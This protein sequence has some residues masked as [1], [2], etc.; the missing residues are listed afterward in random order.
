[1]AEAR[2]QHGD[3]G[4]ATKFAIRPAAEPCSAWAWKNSASMASV[5]SVPTGPAS[6]KLLDYGPD[7][8]NGILTK[9]PPEV[10]D[11]EGYTILIPASDEDGN[12]IPGIRAPMVQAPM[13]PTV[14]IS[15][16]GVEPSIPGTF[17]AALPA[18]AI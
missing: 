13:T 15:R 16:R 2:R 8:D 10:L 5:T 6:L 14:R 1:M 17:Q 4:F 3:P 18:S 9:E 11:A 7:E 12:D